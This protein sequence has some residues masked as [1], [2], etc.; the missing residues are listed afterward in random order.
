MPVDAATPARGRPV[1]PS[2][3]DLLATA[4]VLRAEAL[5]DD[6]ERVRGAL[7]RLRDDVVHHLRA[8][9]GHLATAPAAARAVVLGGQRRLLGLLEEAIGDVR[10]CACL[11]R[12]TELEVALRR[13]A[14]L[15]S[16]LLGRA[17]R[18]PAG[19]AA[20]GQSS[21]ATASG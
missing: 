13:Q 14:R 16:I 10:T 21:E 9:E 11:V 15:E 5:G 12:T 20:A 1:V 19:R 7:A 8:E 4:R 2:H 6:G 3:D 18:A 17:E